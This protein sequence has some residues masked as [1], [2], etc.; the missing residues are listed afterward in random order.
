MIQAFLADMKISF[1][2][3][4]QLWATGNY[5]KTISARD[6]I[7]PRFVAKRHHRG[8]NHSRKIMNLQYTLRYFIMN[9]P[10]FH[11][12]FGHGHGFLICNAINESFRSLDVIHLIFLYFSVDFL[13]HLGQHERV[14]FECFVPCLVSLINFCRNWLVVSL[15][16]NTVSRKS[17]ICFPVCLSCKGRSLT[18]FADPVRWSKMKST[19]SSFD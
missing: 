8:I 1:L 5:N 18:D 13:C 14:F 12:H 6:F 7:F 16:P 11:Q 9:K 19:K 4:R 17:N 3:F 10:F 15:I 2:F